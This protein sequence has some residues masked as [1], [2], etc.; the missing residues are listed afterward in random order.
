MLKNVFA[1][2][3]KINDK[4]SF[5]RNVSITSTWNILGILTQ[6]ILSP[7]ITRLYTPAQYGGFALYNTIIINVVLISSLRYSE[8]IVITDSPEKR[9]NVVSLAFILAA[10][11]TSLSALA[12]FLFQTPIQELIGSTWPFHYIYIIPV[13]ILLGAALEILV[14]LNVWRRK[15]FGNGLAGFLTNGLS[16]SFT[17]LYALAFEARV[18]GLVSGDLVGKV[19]GITSILASFRRLKQGVVSFYKSVTFNGMRVVAKQYR[20]F[21]LY[22]LPTNLLILFSGH[23]PIYFFQ[24]KFTS[25]VVGA[26]ALS[27]SLLEM[28][29]RL[30][31][32]SLAGVFFPKA[33]DLK[34]VSDEHLM[35]KLY[36]LYRAVFL[37]SIG[38]FTILGLFS[39]YLFPLVFGDSWATAGIY[40]GLLSLYYSFHFVAISISDVYK[41]INRQRFLLVATIFSVL[42][43]L[44]VIVSAEILDAGVINTLF[45]FCIGSSLGAIIQIMGVFVIFR[46]KVLEVAL[47]LLAMMA[48]FVL[49]TYLANF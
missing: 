33:M 49:L 17:I 8:A 46:Y 37:L 42:I 30:I 24:I 29:N 9:N 1:Q 12:V 5:T 22:T 28:I 7:I 6:F 43:K 34:N 26:Y 2:L 21:P 16:R 45:W 38:I 18:M 44:L 11:T 10:I 23:L 20:H 19:V 14:T 15:F 13:A 32:Y 27:S 39:K 40:M 35:E 47:S 41:V 4:G 31:P 25:G 3:K 36:K 48:F